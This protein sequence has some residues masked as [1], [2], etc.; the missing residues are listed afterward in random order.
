MAFLLSLSGCLH[1]GSFKRSGEQEAGAAWNP[2]EIFLAW[3]SG[4]LNTVHAQSIQEP[5]V[6]LRAGKARKSTTQVYAGMEHIESPRHS[7]CHASSAQRMV[8]SLQSNSA[9]VHSRFS[10]LMVQLL[11]FKHRSCVSLGTQ[12]AFNR[13]AWW[14]DLQWENQDLK[15]PIDIL[16]S[17]HS[18]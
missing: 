17:I 16:N 15:L 2:P 12:Q 18:W 4:E 6:F 10:L 7:D 11:P 13:P 1:W 14:K 8:R 5:T 3:A 9:W